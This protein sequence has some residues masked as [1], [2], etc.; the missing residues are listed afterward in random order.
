MATP[1]AQPGGDIAGVVVVSDAN[2][3]I[4]LAHVDALH[5]LAELPDLDFVVLDEVLAE[6]S[7]P[8]Q[9]ETV[10]HRQLRR[11]REV[12]RQASAENG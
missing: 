12:V 2:V 9:R 6:V 8:R 4:N 11:S 5:L 10:H 7:R 1:R 3:L